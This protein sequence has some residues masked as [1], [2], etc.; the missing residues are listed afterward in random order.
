[1]IEI[2]SVHSEGIVERL[3]TLVTCYTAANTDPLPWQCMYT[4]FFEAKKPNVFGICDGSNI[5]SL[6]NGKCNA[7]AFL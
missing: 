7:K 4:S 2:D 1:M 6:S 5:G 3:H